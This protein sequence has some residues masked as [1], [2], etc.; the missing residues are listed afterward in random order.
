MDNEMEFEFEKS[1]DLEKIEE[2]IEMDSEEFNSSEFRS[3]KYESNKV[4][5]LI[6][7]ESGEVI[8][9]KKLTPMDYIKAIA[10]KLGQTI[11]N[12]KSNCKFCYGRGHINYISPGSDTM[13]VPCRCIYTKESSESEQKMPVTH[14]RKQRRQM[15]KMSKKLSKKYRNLIKNKGQEEFKKKEEIDNVTN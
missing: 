4:E 2:T 9:R 5:E 6:D 7:S 12:P 3:E 13:P 1:E 8:D 15:D 10:K 14:N 11:K